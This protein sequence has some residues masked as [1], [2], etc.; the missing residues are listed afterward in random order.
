MSLPTSQPNRLDSNDDNSSDDGEGSCIACLMTGV[1]T[2]TGLSLYFMKLASEL[3]DEGPKKVMKEA[4][5]Q[6]R[7]LMGCSAVW[8]GAGVYRL[9]LG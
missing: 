1:A 8:A 5:S 2:C 9:Y 6:K 4:K 3:P 7:F